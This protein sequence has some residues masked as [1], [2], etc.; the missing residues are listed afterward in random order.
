VIISINVAFSRGL[1]SFRGRNMIE[2][3]RRL[4]HALL[5]VLLTSQSKREMRGSSLAIDLSSHFIKAPAKP[6]M[7]GDAE[8]LEV[9]SGFNS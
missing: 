9:F 8:F 7:V 1:N 6:S 4:C 2:A 5:S 3:V